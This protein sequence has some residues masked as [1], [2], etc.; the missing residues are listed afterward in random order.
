MLK[1]NGLIHNLCHHHGSCAKGYLARRNISHGSV[2][3]SN[4]AIDHSEVEL[5]KFWLS[6]RVVQLEAVKAF[7]M[8]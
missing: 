1:V 5:V 6:G 2:L 7:Q 3:A 4:T 8:R